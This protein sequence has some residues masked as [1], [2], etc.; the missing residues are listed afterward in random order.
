ML[1]WFKWY[2]WEI[3]ICKH[4]NGVYDQ[5]YNLGMDRCFRCNKCNKVMK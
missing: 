2:F 3:R 4:D 1:S 5:K